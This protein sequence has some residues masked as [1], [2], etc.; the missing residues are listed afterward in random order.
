MGVPAFFKWLITRYPKVVIDSVEELS[1]ESQLN[2]L[3]KHLRT[4]D[5]DGEVPPID[6]FYLDMNGIIHPCCHP[7]NKVFLILFSLNLQLKRKC[8][9]IYLNILIN[10]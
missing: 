1:N 3:T 8:S 2:D 5:F 4:D 6:N 9:I 10:L 7:I